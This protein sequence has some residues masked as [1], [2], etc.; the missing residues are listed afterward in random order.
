MDNMHRQG[1]ASV[2]PPSTI[3]DTVPPF[4][5][6]VRA[7]AD[8]RLWIPLAPNLTTGLDHVFDVVDRRGVLVDR[9]RVPYPIVGFGPGGNV[10]CFVFAGGIGHLERVRVPLTGGRSP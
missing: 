1:P 2:I 10:Y 8:N 4:T 7:D 5:T 6:G 9:V 3:P